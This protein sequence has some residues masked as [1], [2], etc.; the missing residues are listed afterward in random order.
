[1]V[2]RFKNRS[3]DSNYF[4]IKTACF[5][6]KRGKR[7]R[8]WREQG[9]R[10]SAVNKHSMAA[11]PELLKTL[12]WG[13]VWNKK[14]KKKKR[15]GSISTQS[16]ASAFENSRR[17]SD[18]SFKRCLKKTSFLSHKHTSA[19]PLEASRKKKKKQ[20]PFK[21]KH[22]CREINWW[23]PVS[24]EG[25]INCKLPWIFFF[26]RFFPQRCN[27]NTRTDARCHWNAPA[28]RWKSAASWGS[29]DDGTCSSSTVISW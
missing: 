13:L 17:E 29:G 9:K 10:T 28:K 4:R 15:Y 24:V 27:E 19:S 8:E 11:T 14:L 23:K 20:T 2:P 25:P 26:S 7:G 5:Q 1:M 16:L 12:Y 6:K 22:G 3:L 21:T 18:L